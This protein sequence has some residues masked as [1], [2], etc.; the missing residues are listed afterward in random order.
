MLS[1]RVAQFVSSCDL[2]GFDVRALTSVYQEHLGRI[3]LVHLSEGWEISAKNT[4]TRCAWTPFEGWKVRGRLRRVVLRG[5]DTYRDGEVLA[6]P[7]YGKN[8][9]DRRGENG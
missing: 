1:E 7:G 4:F 3:P 2:A 6:R 9:R 5:K 8:V